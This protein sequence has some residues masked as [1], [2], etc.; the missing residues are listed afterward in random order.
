M[1]KEKEQQKKDNTRHCDQRSKT[2]SKRN[3]NPCI[4]KRET[5][6]GEKIDRE[7]IE[8]VSSGHREG[9]ERHREA[10]RGHRESIE[11][12]SRGYREGTERESLKRENLKS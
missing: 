4:F 10:S 3:E 2:N 7:S 9:I 6:E 5:V 8:R 12:V 11:R 1:V